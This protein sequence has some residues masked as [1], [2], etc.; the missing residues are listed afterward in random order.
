[1]HVWDSQ[2]KKKKIEELLKGKLFKLFRV[3]SVNIINFIDW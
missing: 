3:P 1:M 2:I